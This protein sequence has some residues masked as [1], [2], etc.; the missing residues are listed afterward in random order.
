MVNVPRDTLRGRGAVTEQRDVH[1][2][3]TVATVT[4]NVVMRHKPTHTKDRHEDHEASDP[5]SIMGY[6]QEDFQNF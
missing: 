6:L 3:V 5:P 2:Q 1:E 4:R